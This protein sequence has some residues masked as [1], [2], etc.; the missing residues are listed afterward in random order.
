MQ[1]L[2]H[3]NFFESIKEGAVVVDIGASWCPDCKRIEP[4]MQALESEYAGKV[5]FFEVSFDNEVELKETLQIR[6]IPTLIFY[7]D[8]QEVGERLVEPKNK[9]VIESALQAIV[10]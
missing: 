3:S 9:A 1:E 10:E 5:R 4:I 2:N 7:R 8:G 6:R